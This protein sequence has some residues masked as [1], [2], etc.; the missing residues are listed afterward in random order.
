MTG[1]KAI[2]NKRNKRARYPFYCM[3]VGEEFTCPADSLGAQYNPSG[4][5]LRV[6]GAASVYSR[7]HGGKFTTKKNEDGSVTVVRVK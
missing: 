4:R 3:S 2:R 5:L 1:L 7:R 6:T